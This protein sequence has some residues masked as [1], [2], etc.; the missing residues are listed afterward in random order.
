MSSSSSTAVDLGQPS[1]PQTSQPVSSDSNIGCKHSL[2]CAQSP[3]A[4]ANPLQWGACVVRALVL[5]G[6][7]LDSSQ[8]SRPIEPTEEHAESPTANVGSI[9]TSTEISSQAALLPADA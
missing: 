2:A 1:L 5:T 7:C 6:L 3:E 4:H 8:A 9:P